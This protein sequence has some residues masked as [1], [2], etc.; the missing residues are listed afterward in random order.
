MTVITINALHGEI[1]AGE[2]EVLDDR[3]EIFADPYKVADIEDGISL[4]ALP[5]FDMQSGDMASKK[6]FICT[7]NDIIESNGM[8]YIPFTNREE[9]AA[10]I[11]RLE[12][13]IE[14]QY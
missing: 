7:D 3:K 13:M 4:Y 14:L 8:G 1:K 12:K 10:Y 9:A 11:S 6:Y 2:I 5:L